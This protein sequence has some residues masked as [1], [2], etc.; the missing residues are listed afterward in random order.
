MRAVTRAAVVAALTA[1][2]TG[3]ASVAHAAEEPT[4]AWTVSTAGGSGAFRVDAT[5]A[6][7]LVL[8]GRPNSVQVTGVATAPG[9][10]STTVRC[11]A[12]RTV[13]ATMPGPTAT[14][15]ARQLWEIDMLC[16]SAEATFVTGTVTAPLTCV[17]P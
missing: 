14:L 10:L 2:V 7:G 12:S 15:T 4:D 16:V 3:P 6:F 8:P 1:L 17:T 5:C 11:H 9:A 13:S